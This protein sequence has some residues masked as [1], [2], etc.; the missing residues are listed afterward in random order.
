MALKEKLEQIKTLVE[1]GDF[2]LEDWSSLFTNGSRFEL[3]NDFLKRT[4]K[5][6][7]MNSCFFLFGINSSIQNENNIVDF[8][9]V[10][11]SECEDWKNAFGGTSNSLA[12][13]GHIRNLDMCAATKISSSFVNTAHIKEISF[14]GSFGGNSTTESLT[15]NLS[16][17]TGMSKDDFINTFNTIQQNI[18]ENT[19]IIKIP[20]TIYEELTENELAIATNKGYTITS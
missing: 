7:N 15:L 9:N 14:K 8:H 12:F 19:R 16:F 4:K 5:I 10:D 20:T 18:N 6:K 2:T 11:F 17:C 1:S 3:F 13:W